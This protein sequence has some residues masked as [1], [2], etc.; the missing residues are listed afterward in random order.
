MEHGLPFRVFLV[1]GLSVALA[2]AS[3]RSSAADSFVRG[4]VDQSSRLD[5]SDAVSVLRFLFAGERQL[6]TCDDAADA[7]DSGAIDA[8][9][10]VFLLG[11]LFRGGPMPSGPFP[12]CGEDPTEDA[13][14]CDD[15]EVCRFAFTFF[16]RS[17][18]A[19]GVFFV[20]DRSGSML[21]SGELQL[22][23]QEIISFIEVAP[24]ET[25]FG[26]VLFASN[27]AKFPASGTAAEATPE[28]KESATAFVNSVSSG[29]GSCVQQ[30]LVAA[31][32]FTRSSGA[33]RNVIIYVGDGGGT[34]QGADEATYLN[35]TLE[36]V[37]AENGGAA[38]IHTIGVLALTTIGERFLMDLASRNGGTFTW[39]R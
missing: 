24:P 6:V 18:A 30:G 29:G 22:A 28:M 36:T 37:T 9:D 12:A 23:K 8:S 4:D 38:R 10:A 13:L 32:G 20:V 17:Y 16:G 5:V 39:I 19:D 31:V 35:R 7:D 11:A 27:L 34:C 2:I 3:G 33:R 15:Y 25:R 26:I 21:D 14:G 1:A